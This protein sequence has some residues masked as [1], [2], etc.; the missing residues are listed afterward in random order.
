M[1]LIVMGA[2]TEDYIYQPN[3]QAWKTIGG[4]PIYAAALARALKEP[5]GIVSK[6]GLDL[7][8]KYLRE[9]K[10]LQAN[11]DGFTIEG[12]T[13]MRFENRYLKDG[14]RIQKVLSTSSSISK[15]DIP[16]HFLESP[17]L[18]LGPVY[19]EIDPTIIPSIR[20]YFNIISLDIQGYIRAI[21]G[22]TGEVTIDSWENY[23]DY[24]SFID[25]LKAD[26]YEL[27]ALTK[28]NKLSD[29]IEKIRKIG[30]DQLLVSLGENGVLV[31]QGKKKYSIPTFSTTIKDTTGAGDVFITAFLIEYIENSDPLEAALFASAASSFI[32]ETAGAKTKFTRNDI[33]K[34]KRKLKPKISE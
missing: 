29:A 27:K 16:Q 1:K 4:V 5:I 15:K 12:P 19:H 21:D 9:I 11:L 32:L 7:K 18:H 13:S 6:V 30:I 25:V 2:I 22:E 17:C 23:Q 3:G 20:E 33:L 31:Y 28:T 8:T 14:T 24:L 10:K 34:R 26:E